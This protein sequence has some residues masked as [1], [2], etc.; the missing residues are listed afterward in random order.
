[1]L[2]MMWRWQ[3]DACQYTRPER[4]LFIMFLIDFIKGLWQIMILSWNGYSSPIQLVHF[5]STHMMRSNVFGA[6]KPCLGWKTFLITLL[7]HF[8]VLT[9]KDSPSSHTSVLGH[10]DAAIWAIVERSFLP[11]KKGDKH[12]RIEKQ[13]YGSCVGHLLAVDDTY[14]C[15]YWIVSN[16]RISQALWNHLCWKKWNLDGY[17]Y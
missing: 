7:L 4:C 12:G 15:L 6:E 3:H 9:L 10:K 5:C 11:H 17:H 1:M 13:E 16:R 2:I 8:L 14:L